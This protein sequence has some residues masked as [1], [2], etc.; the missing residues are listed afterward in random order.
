MAEPGALAALVAAGLVVLAANLPEI[1]PADLA[2]MAPTGTPPTA[3]AVAAV[4]ALRVGLATVATAAIMVLVG[5]LVVLAVATQR[6]P[7]LRA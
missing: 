7:A 5:A 4:A 3:R 1:G 2:S 6:G